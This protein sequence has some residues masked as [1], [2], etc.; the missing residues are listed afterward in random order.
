MHVK[1]F[2]ITIKKKTLRLNFQKV[3]VRKR[4]M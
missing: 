4:K 3:R 1:M 2:K